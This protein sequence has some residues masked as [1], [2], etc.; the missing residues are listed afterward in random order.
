MVGWY[1]SGPK[2]RSSDLAINALFQKYITNPVLV[3][4][5]VQPQESLP[6]SAYFAM[7]EIHEDG[8]AATHTFLH[9]ASA[10]EA[11][12]AE[13]IGVEHLLR[14]VTDQFLGGR[15]LDV[16]VADSLRSLIGLAERLREIEGYLAKVLEKKLPVNQQ[17]LSH[18]QDIVNLLPDLSDPETI[19]SFQI[20]TN[21]NMV[22]IYISSLVRAILALHQLINNKLENRK[23][24]LQETVVKETA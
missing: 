16:Q 20:K 17:I 13:E 12:E 19:R 9:L 24:E 5:N 22:V 2:L 8:T 15:S 18:L 3:V 1:H 23:L 10:I 7:E 11:E 14:D 6:T 4:V 21:D